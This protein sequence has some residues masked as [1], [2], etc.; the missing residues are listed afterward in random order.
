M[1]LWK[2]RDFS[3]Q[4]NNLLVSGLSTTWSRNLNYW[5]NAMKHVWLIELRSTF[6]LRIASQATYTVAIFHYSNLMGCNL[7]F[8]ITWIFWELELCLY[9]LLY[10]TNCEGLV[11]CHWKR[12]MPKWDRCHF[13]AWVKNTHSIVFHSKQFIKVKKGHQLLKSDHKLHINFS[14]RALVGG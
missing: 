7:Y 5:I 4:L 11:V 13:Y 1:I 3:E 8:P 10:F 14:S 6:T 9:F 2:R 12:E